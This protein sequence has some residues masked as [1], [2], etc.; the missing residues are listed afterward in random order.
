[1]LACCLVAAL[2]LT[3]CPEGK[4]VQWIDEGD[5]CPGKAWDDI[6]KDK[7]G[8]TQIG[9]TV[10]GAHGKTYGGEWRCKDGRV[11]VRCE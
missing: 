4:N 6:Q 7:E 1:M 8:Q 9:G 3:G 5:S 2:P 11:I 10:C